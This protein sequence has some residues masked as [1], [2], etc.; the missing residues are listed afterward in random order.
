MH[1][2][3]A[4]TRH[5]AGQPATHGVGR[6]ADDAET[7]TGKTGD[8]LRQQFNF[9][10]ANILHRQIADPHRHVAPFGKLAG[11]VGRGGILRGGTQRLQHRL[12]R[13]LFDVRQRKE[14]VQQG[15]DHRAG[16]D[17]RAL[18]HGHTPIIRSRMHHAQARAFFH[19]LTQALRQQ[20]RIF[21]QETADDQ[22]AV[23]MAHLRQ[24]HSQTGRAV[25]LA[26]GTEIA[27]PQAKINVFRTQRAHQFL[28]Q[29][30]L[31]ERGMRRSK[32]A[33]G[34]RTLLVERGLAA[35]G[36]KFQRFLP[37]DFAPLRATANHRRTQALIAI[38]GFV[39]KAVFIRQPAFVDGFIF[40]RQHALDAVKAGLHDEV[41]AHAIVRADRTAAR[42]F[43]GARRKT[44]RARSQ[45]AHRAQVND[46]AGQFG[47][48][49]APEERHDFGVLAAIRLPQ[50]HVAGD[51]L[52][53]AHAAGAVDAAGHVGGDQRAEV[54]V[55]HDA[56]F[57]TIARLV[58][59][60]ADRQILQ[61]AFAALVANRAIQRVIDEQKLHHGL[62]R[63]HGVFRMRPHF[64][65][66]GHGRGT[67]GQR[68]GRLFYL[69]QTHAAVGGNR[70]LAVIAKVRNVDA[71]EVGCF[72]HGATFVYLERFS[73]DFNL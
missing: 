17:Q 69:H 50:F 33:N 28:Q 16:R 51:F 43:P 2:F 41:R 47:I 48:E 49:R 54:F 20:R 31:F 36:D 6:F 67:G 44:E 66:V 11:D 40:Q 72:H 24:R 38:E 18:M 37:T 46:V 30:Q 19:R 23:K 57:F 52:H 55:E 32:R 59:A 56:L 45:R 8:F 71:S 35:V 3:P 70:Q 58:A 53:E 62:L 7:P 42:Q 63:P 9:G 4:R 61:L 12:R 1:V 34:R 68:L 60:V 73:V 10:A 26:V 15:V 22:Q 27:V 29:V 21:A 39:G 13:R 25:A 5:G 65:A 14:D 64:H